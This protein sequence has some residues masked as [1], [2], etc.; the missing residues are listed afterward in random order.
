VASPC[1]EGKGGAAG[2][3]RRPGRCRSTRLVGTS[4]RGASQAPE[5]PHEPVKTRRAAWTPSHAAFWI[6]NFG[7]GA[8]VRRPAE[9]P[10]GAAL[11]WFYYPSAEG[12][13][14]TFVASGSASS[15]NTARLKCSLLG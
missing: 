12:M 8:L 6:F 15:D 2:E 5:D 13:A 3:A 11:F 1:K 4:S 10:V 9:F 7:K 14:N